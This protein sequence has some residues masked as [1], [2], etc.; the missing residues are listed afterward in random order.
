MKS[1]TPRTNAETFMAL[2]YT[3]PNDDNKLS[4]VYSGFARELE[5]ENVKLREALNSA[6]DD[7]LRF[8]PA[9]MKRMQM[10]DAIDAALTAAEGGPSEAEALGFDRAQYEEIMDSGERA[11]KQ[12]HQPSKEK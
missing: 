3:K 1:D 9:T 2:P 10:V 8:M 5:R 12:P 6:H 4:V 11:M 7:I